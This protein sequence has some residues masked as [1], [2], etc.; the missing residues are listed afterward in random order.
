MGSY[1]SSDSET[2]A[3][4]AN[5]TNLDQV[6]FSKQKFVRASEPFTAP[7]EETQQKSKDDVDI[8]VEDFLAVRTS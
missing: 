3:E 8:K 6:D 4:S 7:A 1:A 2:E 5:A